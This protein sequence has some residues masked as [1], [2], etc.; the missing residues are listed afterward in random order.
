MVTLAWLCVLGLLTLFFSNWLEK[1]RNPNQQVQ[2]Q[3]LADKTRTVTLERNRYGHYVATGHI[4]GHAVELLLDTGATTVS[5]PQALA[6]KLGLKRG[7]AV[8]TSTANGMI[9][10]YMTSLDKVQLGDITLYNVAAGINPNSE[11][12]LLG[13][14]FLKQLEFTQR[15]NQLILKQH[16][17]N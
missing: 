3:Q 9:T 4:N 5:V 2:S 13:M 10:T 6:R 17:V 7:T 1:Q 15:G 12:I 16:P 8:D 11:H 14:S